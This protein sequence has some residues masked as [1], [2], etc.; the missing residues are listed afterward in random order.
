MFATGQTLL[1]NWKRLSKSVESIVSDAQLTLEHHAVRLQTASQ[2][3]EG[4][5]RYSSPS[6]F[7]SASGN[8]PVKVNTEIANSLLNSQ[9]PATLQLTLPSNLAHTRT[10]E[11][12]TLD[13]ETTA[14]M[15]RE[16]VATIEGGLQQKLIWDASQVSG[17]DSSK[18]YWFVA[19]FPQ[20]TLNQM[21]QS[22]GQTGWNLRHVSLTP[23][24]K[25]KRMLETSSETDHPCLVIHLDTSELSFQLYDHQQLYYFRSLSRINFMTLLQP[26]MEKWNLSATETVMM[27]KQP[28]FNRQIQSSS[29][30]ALLEETRHSLRSLLAKEVTRTLSYLN[31]QRELPK[32]KT[33]L[34]TDPAP[35]LPGWTD[36]LDSLLGPHISLSQA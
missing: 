7:Q 25:A 24:I 26:L 2:Q 23:L 22:I 17:V 15:I 1:N 30:A 14:S 8:A 21:T 36:H 20:T 29:M 5:L 27:L 6:L 11:L 35:L 28:V 3:S 9:R 12:P 16:E 18:S 33:C 32:V 10:L 34:I 31:Q 13:S 19:C 4:L